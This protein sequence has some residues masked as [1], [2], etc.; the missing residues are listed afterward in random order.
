[1]CNKI[2]P[3]CGKPS[4]QLTGKDNCQCPKIDDGVKYLMDMGLGLLNP[5][6]HGH[7]QR[8]QAPLYP[9]RQQSD[10]T[11]QEKLE[12]LVEA[13][14]RSAELRDLAKV[15]NQPSF[16]GFVVGLYRWIRI[17]MSNS[18]YFNQIGKDFR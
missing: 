5:I 14:R 10:W 7:I 2:C 3:T 15:Y 16:V 13:E 11:K 4:P 18:K 17:A 9:Q 6:S 8:T 1:M 12:M